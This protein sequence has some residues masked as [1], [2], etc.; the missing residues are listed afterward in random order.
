[1]NAISPPAAAVS[2]IESFQVGKRVEK[3]EMR[4]RGRKQKV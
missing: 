1:M 4:P 2:A 3:V